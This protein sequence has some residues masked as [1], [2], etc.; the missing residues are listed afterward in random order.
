MLS[1][2]PPP[3]KGDLP[4]PA[5]PAPVPAAEPAPEQA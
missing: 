2:L 5:A 1:G 4:A 3:V